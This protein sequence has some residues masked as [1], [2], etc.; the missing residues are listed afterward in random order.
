MEGTG[1]LI[2]G[3]LVLG[4]G[5]LLVSGGA[6]AWFILPEHF[7]ATARVVVEPGSP[8]GPGGLGSCQANIEQIQ[9]REVLCQVVSNLSLER[10]WAEQFKETKPLPMAVTCALLRHRLEVRP[11]RDP[12]LVEIT[13]ESQDRFE[14]AQLANELARVCAEVAPGPAAQE[15][16]AARRAAVRLIEQA[17]PPLHPV[18][19][20]PLPVMLAAVAGLAL[21]GGGLLLLVLPGSPRAGSA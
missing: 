17:R 7:L 9:S 16:G 13:A 20:R 11:N 3:V 1:R 10:R 6:L 18:R 21:T 8:G 15:P 4:A 2:T 19:R 14:A 5:V 12:G